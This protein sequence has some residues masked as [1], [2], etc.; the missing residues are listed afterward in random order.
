[1]R[2]IMSVID[3]T[4]NERNRIHHPLR[5]PLCKMPRICH[6]RRNLCTSFQYKV[7]V[8]WISAYCAKLPIF[9]EKST[10]FTPFSTLFLKLIWCSRHFQKD[11]LLESHKSNA[12]QYSKA[13]SRH[14]SNNA[15]TTH[16]RSGV[17]SFAEARH[18]AFWQWCHCL[19]WYSN[20]CPAVWL[21]LM[22]YSW[23]TCW[24]IIPMKQ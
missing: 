10:S 9:S 11:T 18:G 13:Q 5:K 8:C 15:D 7:V 3:W 24:T 17:P 2:T 12:G 20:C 4:R 19:L 1:M 16:D 22:W 23:R 14:Q 6:V 21:A